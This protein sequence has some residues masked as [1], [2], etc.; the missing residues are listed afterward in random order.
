MKQI[1]NSNPRNDINGVKTIYGNN[2][3]SNKS[4]SERMIFLLD[5]TIIDPGYILFVLDSNGCYIDKKAS[6]SVFKP[7]S[8]VK[9]TSREIGRL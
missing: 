5:A 4:S 7:D 9:T 8:C 3:V 1:V 2:I 6:S